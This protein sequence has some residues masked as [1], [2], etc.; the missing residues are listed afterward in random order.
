M[1]IGNGAPHDSIGVH[2]AP[3]PPIAAPRPNG[4]GGEVFDQSTEKAVNAWTGH[5]STRGQGGRLSSFTSSSIHS[6]NPED[7]LLLAGHDILTAPRSNI[8]S[9]RQVRFAHQNTIS[10][11][12]LGPP[13][14]RHREYGFGTPVKVKTGHLV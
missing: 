6:S 12:I 4:Q 5:P 3:V 13:P 10:S 11:R 7:G 9:G 2:Y 14:G 1:K 8:R